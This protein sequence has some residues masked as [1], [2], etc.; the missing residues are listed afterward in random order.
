MKGVIRIVTFLLL[1]ATV[2]SCS[3]GKNAIILTSGDASERELFGAAKLRAA[4]TAAGYQVFDVDQG[5][6][7]DLR[8]VIGTAADTAFS[9]AASA[10]GVTFVPSTAREGFS[11]KSAGQKL[12]VAGND[13][14]GALYGCIELCDRLAADKKLPA[15]IDF[16]DAPEM[17]LR[18]ACI[19]VQKTYYLPGR[20]V[21]EYPYTPEEFPWFYDKELWVKYLDML[22]D[23]RMNSLYLWN[24][25]PFASLVKLDDYPFA[26]EVDDETF[27]KN[28]EMYG[29]LT[30]EANKRGIFVIQMF[31]NVLVSKPFAEHYGIRTQ[32]RSRPII[33]LIADYTRKSI[34]AFVERYPNVGL[35]LTLGE[36]MDTYQ[37]DVDWL[38]KTIIPGVQD[39][40][41][42]LGRTDE[43]PIIVRAH[44]TDPKM[45]MDAALPIYKNLYTM[46]KYNGE[47]LTTYQPGGRW[48]E[49]HRGLSALGSVHIENVHIL[50]NLEPFR[51]G[52]PEFVQ[53][54]VRAM[55]EIHG[56]NGLHLFPQANYWEWP[57]SADS[58]AGGERLL[59]IDRDWIWY[60]AWARYAWKCERDRGQEVAYWSDR[61]ADMYGSSGETGGH[62]MNSYDQMGE[63]SPKLLRK[64]GIT[65]GNRQ[66]MLLG[67]FM[68][69]LVNPAKWTV[70]ADFHSSAGPPGERLQMWA[71]KEW[72]KEPHEGETPPQ[73]IAEAVEHGRLAVE[74]IEKAVPGVKKNKD[75]FARL[76]N[77]AYC[78]QTFARYFSEKVKAAMLVLEYN[79]AKD[80][81]LLD[82]A[83]VHLDQS[84][85]HYRK[86]VDLTRGAYRHAN[87]MQTQQRRIPIGSNGGKYKTWAEML[88]LYEDELV[89]FRKNIAFL[90]SSGEDAGQA[91]VA[92]IPVKVTLSGDARQVTLAAGAKLFADRP[93]VVEEIAAELKDL[94]AVQVDGRDQ[95]RNGTQIVFTC[96]KPVQVVVGYFTSERADYLRAPVLETD[97]SANDF[98]QAEIQIANAV[99]LPGM[100]GGSP[101]IN[102]HTFSYP[103][104]T[105]T[106]SLGRGL[107]LVL[108]FADGGEK[109]ARR[110]AGLISGSQKE[111][112]DWL[113]Y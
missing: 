42:A 37:D 56:A 91:P 44:D 39:G 80:I 104:G 83:T 98:G 47:S 15:A 105:H 82:S 34:A 20:T 62:I 97:A 99:K 85:V 49:T 21:Y 9:A 22:V 29:F 90:K 73:L 27:R 61:L 87:S 107:A 6:D 16:T 28:E 23:N 35:L 57:Y 76:R 46:N 45:V 106:L 11:I 19:G 32:E 64:F 52:S 8:I 89:T 59:E 108:G 48:A 77:D 113:F 92:L 68:S 55:H 14:S 69:Q 93:N 40:L 70:Y 78:F 100:P 101:G 43:P 5:N 67:M 31:Y 58:V 18:G 24:G 12:F 51:W 4:L 7:K 10:A 95:M 109:I 26:V 96:D 30:E 110:D 75:E 71:E 63:I 86:L 25:H 103:A 74:E 54:A 53:K 94:S 65:E 112:V 2:A 66:T 13:P 102:V 3:A 1:A 88:P 33:P 72:N 50:A 81:A 84:L 17:V 60:A 38:T 36:A 79:Y 41:K 111:N